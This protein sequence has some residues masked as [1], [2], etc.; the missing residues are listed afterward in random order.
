MADREKVMIQTPNSQLKLYVDGSSIETSFGARIILVSPNGVNL[1]Y[2]FRFKFKATNN[3]AECEALLASL[4]LAK[5]VL[6]QCLTVYNDSQLV[7][8]QVNSKFKAKGKK[9]RHT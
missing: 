2:A 3:Q 4:R 5:E 1:C 8:S 7:V 9:W 6:A